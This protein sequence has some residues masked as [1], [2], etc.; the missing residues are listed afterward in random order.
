MTPE[1]YQQVKALF[2][3]TQELEPEDRA[4][5]LA[6]RCDGDAS[7]RYAVEELLASAN[8]IEAFIE[9]PAYAIIGQSLANDL[10]APFVEGKRIGQYQI[11]RKLGEGGMGAVY[12]ARRAD[13][14]YEKQVAIKLIRRGFDNAELL[15]RFYNERQI[16]ARLDHPNIARLLDGGATEDGL[17]YSGVRKSPSQ[18]FAL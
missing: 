7:L 3:A 8:K 15:R 17:P 10:S 16:L 2:Y 4:A 1:R 18:S 14:V 6:Q 12:L 13:E 11:L 9:K 5:F